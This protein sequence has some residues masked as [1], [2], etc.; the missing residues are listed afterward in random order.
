[1]TKM[2]EELWDNFFNECDHGA[3]AWFG[4]AHLMYPLIHIAYFQDTVISKQH[5]A[6]LKAK[7]M[8]TSWT[9]CLINTASPREK[10]RVERF[11]AADDSPEN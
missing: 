9:I 5:R 7:S 3:M 11:E 4:G 1:M 2:T 8:K 6:M 10:S